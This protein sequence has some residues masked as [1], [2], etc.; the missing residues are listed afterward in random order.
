MRC[1]VVADMTHRIHP[2]HS[3]HPS[4]TVASCATS[5]CRW[6]AGRINSLLHGG[7]NKFVFCE[8]GNEN[9]ILVISF[10][11]WLARATWNWPEWGALMLLGQRLRR[12]GPGRPTGRRATDLQKQRWESKKQHRAASS[13]WFIRELGGT[14]RSVDVKAELPRDR[15]NNSTG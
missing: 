5:R 13:L 11:M 2:G 1:L 3:Y 7:P 9:Q 6:P 10:C 15:H 12:W 14:V 8:F 4:A